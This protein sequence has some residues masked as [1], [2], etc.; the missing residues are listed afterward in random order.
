[1][2]PPKEVV[3]FLAGGSSQPEAARAYLLTANFYGNEAFWVLLP[4]KGE[5][6]PGRLGDKL[7]PYRL[8]SGLLE[9]EAHRL[10]GRTQVTKQPVGPDGYG[11]IGFQ[12]GGVGFPE[13]GCWEVTYTLDGQ[14]PLRFILKASG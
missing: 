8:K 4:P 10:D 11:D 9:W 1:M 3:D 13:P 12:A 5:L 2:T 7:M 14:H 6:P